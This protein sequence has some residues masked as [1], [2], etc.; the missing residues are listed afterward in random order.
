MRKMVIELLLPL[1]RT[2]RIRMYKILLDQESLQKR[3]FSYSRKERGLSVIFYIF[4]YARFDRVT[5]QLLLLL[6]T[7]ENPTNVAK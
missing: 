5:L 2:S 6:Y 4:L 1:H 7:F 3:P